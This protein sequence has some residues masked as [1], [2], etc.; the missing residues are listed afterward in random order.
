MRTGTCGGGASRSR[1]DRRRARAAT[2]AHRPLAQPRRE[3]SG[4]G[5]RGEAGH[6][7]SQARRRVAPGP[8]RRGADGGGA[9][10]PREEGMSKEEDNETVL[11]KLK[12]VFERAAEM[13]NELSPVLS[14]LF[15]QPDQTV[16][17]MLL[18]HAASTGRYGVAVPCDAP[19][20]QF[21]AAMAFDA[22]VPT[23]DEAEE[24]A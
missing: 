7:H 5:V 1:N 21:L 22:V 18:L 14:E 15:P 16:C 9:G 17:I 6:R 10:V 8:V 11:N 12:P 3:L 20:F 4:Q 2:R 23:A 24:D 13:A 19:T